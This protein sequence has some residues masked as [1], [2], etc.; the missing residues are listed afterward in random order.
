MVDF[1]IFTRQTVQGLLCAG[2]S[3]RNH[4]DGGAFKTLQKSLPSLEIY[5]WGEGRY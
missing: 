1:F 3:P 5:W 4:I 2:Q